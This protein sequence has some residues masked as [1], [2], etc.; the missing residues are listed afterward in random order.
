MLLL[1]LFIVVHFL[2][3]RNIPVYCEG[4]Q[5]DSWQDHRP[6]PVEALVQCLSEGRGEIWSRSE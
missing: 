3:A 1:L 6:C 2:L 5:E 4:V